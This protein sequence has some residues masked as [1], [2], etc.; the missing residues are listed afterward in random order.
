MSGTNEQI[1]ENIKHEGVLAAYCFVKK[2]KPLQVFRNS[3][4]SYKNKL[5]NEF[6][7]D[8]FKLGNTE[9]N[10][11]AWLVR[12]GDITIPWGLRVENFW[13]NGEFE[14]SRGNVDISTLLHR[15]FPFVKKGEFFVLYESQFN[16]YG[17]EGYSI[18]IRDKI[19]EELRM[20]LEQVDSADRESTLKSVL[21]GLKERSNQCEGSVLYQL[22]QDQVL[23]LKNVVYHCSCDDEVDNPKKAIK[24]GE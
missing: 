9:D 13:A 1:S 21:E 7:K 14:F 10:T 17:F 12:T 16:D 18:R 23:T 8:N 22:C 24:Q 2:D 3:V 20:I 15:G 6:G 11:I 5:I 4:E 19:A